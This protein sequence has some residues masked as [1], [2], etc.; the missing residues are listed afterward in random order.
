MTRFTRFAK[1]ILAALLALAFCAGSIRAQS[2]SPQPTPA[3][4]YQALL[5][6]ANAAGFDGFSHQ[7][8]AT[9]DEYREYI[10]LLSQI[11]RSEEP[12]V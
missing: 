1:T 2:P 5:D 8:P 12:H 11:V 10:H 4:D 7:H 6:S 3:P 9:E